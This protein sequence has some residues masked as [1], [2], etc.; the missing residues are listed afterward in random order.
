MTDKK[1]EELFEKAKAATSTRSHGVKTTATQR[2]ILRD[3]REA[4][5]TM[6]SLR[7]TLETKTGAYRNGHPNLD[8]AW[9][10]IARN[11]NEILPRLRDILF[12]LDRLKLP[13]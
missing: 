4:Y 5:E 12:E 9:H 3:V 6:H 7:T 2:R 8:S 1:T 10:I 13:S 11:T